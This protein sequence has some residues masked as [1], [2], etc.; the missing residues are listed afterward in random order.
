MKRIP[1]ALML[2]LKVLISAGLLLFFLSRVD[3]SRFLYALASADFTYVGV[4]LVIYLVAQL[5]S[6]VRWMV[7]ARPLGFQTRFTDMIVYYFIGMFF[8]LFAPSTVGGDVT[9][10]YYLARD[11]GTDQ[12]S[13]WKST[14]LQATI[15]V[16]SDRA[17]GMIVL[18]WLGAAGLA[19]FPWFPVPAAL[20]LLTFGLALGFI[21]GALVLPLLRQILPASSH[22]LV[23]RV[24]VALGTFRQHRSAILFAILISLM[25]HGIQASMHVL[26]GRALH[27]EV[28]LSYCFILYPLVGAFAALPVSFNGI[29]LRE[30]GYLFLLGIIGV[31]SEKAI[32]FGLLLFL[33]GALDSLLGGIAFVLRKT[34]PPAAIAAESEM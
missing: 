13:G 22:V 9:R 30:G 3:L 33:I 23:N 27:I 26:I 17:I 31:D 7:L 18:I 16:L 11:K 25:V 10:V 1:P 2:A 21:V 24:R 32:A 4:V 12:G 29:G 8:N 28:P 34:P 19:L 6:A 14:T 20:R 5:M 15:V